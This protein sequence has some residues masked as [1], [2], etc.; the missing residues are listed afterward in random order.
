MVGRWFEEF[1]VGQVF[2]HPIRL[3]QR[4]DEVCTCTRQA[5]MLRRPA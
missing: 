3:N 4:D 2:E 5:L 1:P